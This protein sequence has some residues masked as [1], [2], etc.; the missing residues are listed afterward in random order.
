MLS[1]CLHGSVVQARRPIQD[2]T[3]CN[4]MRCLRHGGVVHGGVVHRTAHMHCSCKN[5]ATPDRH[6]N[7]KGNTAL[8]AAPHPSISTAAHLTPLLP[9]N[10]PRPRPVAPFFRLASNHS[11]TALS[12]RPKL[13]AA[14][15]TEP[16][17]VAAALSHAPAA[18]A[19]GAAARGTSGRVL[20]INE[21][22]RPRKACPGHSGQALDKKQSRGMCRH[23][24]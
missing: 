12:G 5:A 21:R 20:R 10:I 6:L 1:R 13:G 24:G 18:H 11:G 22:A 4:R 19:A 7:Q 16:N 23:W 9:T 2:V 8:P 15:S 17:L 14:V 3:P